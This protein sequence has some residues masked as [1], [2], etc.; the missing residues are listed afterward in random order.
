M[1]EFFT[2]TNL[3]WLA[4]AMVAT[5]LIEAFA[6]VR[7]PRWAIGLVFIITYFCGV[8]AGSRFLFQLKCMGWRGIP[9]HLIFY[10]PQ[11]ILV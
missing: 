4:V 5:G 9:R 3:V 7:G 2:P 6:D 1:P 10:I 8:A 11:E